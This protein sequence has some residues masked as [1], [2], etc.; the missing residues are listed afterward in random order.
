MQV[1]EK[2]NLLCTEV[3]QPF[4]GHVLLAKGMIQPN[5]CFRSSFV[6]LPDC[7]FRAVSW[8]VELNLPMKPVAWNI[9]H[10]ILYSA[11]SCTV[12]IYT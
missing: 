10:E 2:Q 4:G 3:S 12:L 1:E 5:S 8:E 11:L 9:P 7:D 6:V